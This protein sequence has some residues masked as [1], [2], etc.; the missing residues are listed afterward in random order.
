MEIEEKIQ[1]AAFQCV[2][3]SPF[4]FITGEAELVNSL[5]DSGLDYYHFRKSDSNPEKAK[6]FFSMINPRWYPRIVVHQDFNILDSFALSTIHISSS[7]KNSLLYRLFV[8][9]RLKRNHPQLQLVTTFS[10]INTFRVR[11]GMFKYVFLNNVFTKV[12]FDQSALAYV[13]ATL[14]IK[15]KQ[16]DVPVFAKGMITQ[17]S[18]AQAK[19]LG[20]S[21]VAL[22]EDFWEHP[23][24]K[25]Y[26]ELI[27]TWRS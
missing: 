16:I 24:P 12:A 27:N 8:L 5:F 11:P 2:L 10:D 4:R 15:L 21:G 1:P 19:G 13:K 7:K 20:F 3:F 22:Q 18:L 14:E 17:G 25:A 23:D 26:F 9:S 6:Q